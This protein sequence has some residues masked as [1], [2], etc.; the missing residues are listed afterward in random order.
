MNKKN[1]SLPKAGMSKP[2]QVTLLF[3]FAL[4]T[5][6]ANILQRLSIYKIILSWPF[7]AMRKLMCKLHDI[8]NVFYLKTNIW[9]K[10]QDLQ[11]THNTTAMHI[12]LESTTKV[13]GF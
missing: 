6:Y 8:F 7:Y 5:G 1:G 4:L 12:K 9:E 13:A 11:E 2:V 3:I 10:N